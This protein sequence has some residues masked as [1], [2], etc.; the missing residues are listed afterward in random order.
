MIESIHIADDV[1][2][3]LDLT[4]GRDKGLLGITFSLE[5]DAKEPNLHV[6]PMSLIAPG[7]FRQIFEYR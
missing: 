5:G 1:V 7:I 4:N 2:A 3:H 6:N